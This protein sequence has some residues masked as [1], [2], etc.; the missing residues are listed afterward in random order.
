MNARARVTLAAVLAAGFNLL[1]FGC[2]Q[3]G[4]ACSPKTLASIEA[5]YS[6]KVVALCQGFKF[7]DC[8]A[9]PSLK[10]DRAAEEKAAGCR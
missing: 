1:A 2:R 5:G 10:A 7:E 3:S 6:A 9:V 8:P 4:E